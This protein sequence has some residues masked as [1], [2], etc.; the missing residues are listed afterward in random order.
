VEIASNPPA[1]KPHNASGG[2]VWPRSRTPSEL[3]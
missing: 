1:T 2:N 3:C